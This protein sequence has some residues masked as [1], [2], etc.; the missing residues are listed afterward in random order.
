MDPFNFQYK[1]HLGDGVYVG[2]DGYQ[3]WLYTLQG[4]FIALEPV[5]YR[6]LSMYMKNLQTTLLGDLDETK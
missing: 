2:F 4:E 5:V 6:N 1:E 3:I